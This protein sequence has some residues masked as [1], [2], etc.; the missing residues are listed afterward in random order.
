M[1]I[2][3]EDSVYNSPMFL[4]KQC[5]PILFHCLVI[6]TI[7]SHLMAEHPDKPLRVRADTYDGRYTQLPDDS[8]FE[9][10]IERISYSQDNHL[11]T[12]TY[13]SRQ[14]GAFGC[15][16]S[17]NL[18][19]PMPMHFRHPMRWPQNSRSDNYDLPSA[20]SAHVVFGSD[21]EPTQLESRHGAANNSYSE[22]PKHQAAL[23]QVESSAFDMRSPGLW[24]SN[25]LSHCTERFS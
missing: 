20:D 23:V 22:A 4:L 24:P 21:L 25:L 3:G 13:S 15:S 10:T 5:V 2:S 9:S 16:V 1:I 12:D 6:S 17:N 8:T 18:N 11:S 14:Q 7:C 19:L